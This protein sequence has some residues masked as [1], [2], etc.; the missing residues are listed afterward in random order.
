MLFD[1]DLEICQ[2]KFSEVSNSI[3]IPGTGFGECQIISPQP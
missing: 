3:R 1:G 2:L